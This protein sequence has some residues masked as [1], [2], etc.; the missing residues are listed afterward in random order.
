MDK[1]TVNILQG[2]AVIQTV[3]GGLTIGYIFRLQISD[4]VYV[5]KI[6]NIGW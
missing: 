5:P 1:V 4:S 6:T 3:L 2:S